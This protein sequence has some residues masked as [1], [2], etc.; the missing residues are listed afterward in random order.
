[1]SPAEVLDWFSPFVGGGIAVEEVR[2]C[3]VEVA[4]TG[5][6]RRS[7]VRTTCPWAKWMEGVRC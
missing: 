4:Y 7:T 1:M 5:F 6:W 3:L 2:H